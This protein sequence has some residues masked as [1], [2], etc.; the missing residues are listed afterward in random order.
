MTRMTGYEPQA[1]PKGAAFTPS[2]L[3]AFES[4]PVYVRRAALKLAALTWLD[5]DDEDSVGSGLMAIGEK[6]SDFYD[7]RAGLLVC[8]K[9]LRRGPKPA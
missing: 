2:E 1:A 9:L 5:I 3:G 4:V 8:V 7:H 6:P